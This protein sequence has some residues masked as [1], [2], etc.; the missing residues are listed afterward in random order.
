MMTSIA[1]NPYAGT[2]KIP[3]SRKYSV[4]VCM[5]TVTPAITNPTNARSFDF[6]ARMEYA[7]PTIAGENSR[8]DK[9]M[10]TTAGRPST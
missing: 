4:C 7:N 3:I 6:S 5:S 9:T 2:R 8:Y 10:S 1:A